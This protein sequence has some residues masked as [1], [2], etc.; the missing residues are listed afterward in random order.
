MSNKPTY[1]ELLN[2]I[3]KLIEASKSS[4][5]RIGQDLSLPSGLWHVVA[6]AESVIERAKA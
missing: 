5:K 2:T 1:S 6:G 3:A 4:H